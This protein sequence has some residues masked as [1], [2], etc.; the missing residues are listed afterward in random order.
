MSSFAI[1]VHNLR[2]EYGPKVAVESLSLRVERG[3]AFGFLGPNG[4]GKTTAVK[5]ML[6]LVRPTSGEGKVLGRSIS[7]PLCRERVGFLPEDFR[8]RQWLRGDEFLDLHAR[9]HHVPRDVRTERIPELL[10]LVGLEDAA[11]RPLGDYSKGMLQRIG[12]AQALVNDPELVFLDEPTSGLDPLGRRMVREI[13]RRLRERGK[14]V[15]L[16]SH[17]LGEVELTC[18]RVAVVAGGRVRLVTDPRT[19]G[20]GWVQV[21]LR[22]GEISEELLSGLQRWS[23]DVRLDEASRTLTLRLHD[24][25]AIPEIAR[26]LVAEDVA[27]YALSPRRLSLE[28][29]FVRVVEGEESCETS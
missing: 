6:G 23:D 1:D 2:K 18:N 22:V 24:A 20:D 25:E 29:L 21:D 12:L 27:L 13:I 8:F 3:E 4:A 9:L 17:L 5:M 26:W 19:Y 14:T 15:F 28:D 7:D 10:R 11:N 16:N